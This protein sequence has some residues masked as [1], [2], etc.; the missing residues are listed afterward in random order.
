VRSTICVICNVREDHLDE[1]G[2]TLDDVAR[3]LSRSM[4]AGGICV[5]AERE[6][7][8]I[9][10]EEADKRGCE[11]V[12]VD[13]ESV[14]DDEME[15]FRW[16]TFKENVAIALAVAQLCGVGRGEAMAGMVAARPDPGTVTVDSYA[17]GRGRLAFANVF[18]AN[19]PE[20]TLMNIHLLED[21]GLLHDPLTVVINCR[22]DRIERNGQMGELT[23]RIQPD[24]I[25]L[26]GEQTHS[27]R[28]KVPRGLADRVVD[29][30]G[31]L[32]MDAFLDAVA[33]GPRGH[34]CVVAVGNIHG[35]GE[36]LL[37]HVAALP[38]AVAVEA[39]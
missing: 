3:S 2:P 21:R 35:Q 32:D 26:I 23:G 9:L 12:V 5:T 11:L 8:H 39:A 22:P 14:R 38:R 10:Q 28:A 24:R 6:R 37:S 34:A 7:L 15:R 13:P 31:D 33:Y 25:V 16:I 4:P 17:T 30:G 20:S 36:V 1:M 19:D 18:A 27:A 29:L